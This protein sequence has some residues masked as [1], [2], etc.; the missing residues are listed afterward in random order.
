MCEAGDEMSDDDDVDMEAFRALLTDQ[1]KK[2]TKVATEDDNG[3]LDG[4]KFR[5]LIVAKWGVPY[6]VQL[7]RSVFLGKPMMVLNVMWKYYGQQSFHLTEMEYLEHLQA[8]AELVNKW[9]RVQHV[10]DLINESKKRPAGYFGYAVSIPLD[11]DPEVMENIGGDFVNM[12]TNPDY[13]DNKS[14]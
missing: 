1:W 4:Y 9:E 11:L 7:Q 2:T 12:P 5:D 14:A 13:G 3:E 10:K 6:D 8:L